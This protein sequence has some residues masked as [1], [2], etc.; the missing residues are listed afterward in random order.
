MMPSA[1]H[2]PAN[3]PQAPDARP[4]GSIVAKGKTVGVEIFELKGLK[5][6]ASGG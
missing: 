1:D 3:G 5:R 2:A 4:L 6:R